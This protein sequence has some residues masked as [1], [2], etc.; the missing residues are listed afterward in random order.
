MKKIIAAALSILVAAFG[1]TIVDSTIEN[2]VA[3][4]E[5]EVIELREEIS[6]NHTT[7][8]MP[9]GYETTY[10]PTT[11]VSTTTERTDIYEGRFFDKSD[12]S[13]SKFLLRY[14]ETGRIEYI[15][16]GKYETTTT[17]VTTATEKMTTLRETTTLEP[18]I[19]VTTIDGEIITTTHFEEYDTTT[20]RKTTT[21]PTTVPSYD[22][23]FL[24]LTNSSVQITSVDI[25]EENSYW[26][27]NDYSLTSSPIDTTTMTVTATY[28]G[29]TDP[30]FAGYKVNIYNEFKSDRSNLHFYPG[31][32]FD[33]FQK[34]DNTIRS[35]GSFEYTKHIS[36]PHRTV[37]LSL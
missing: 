22:E 27:D 19:E 20:S 17:R 26:Y 29:Y 11:R 25:K 10:S 1:Y 30:I 15:S 13:K 33:E 35:D 2:R 3:S 21:L 9:T 32:R 16:P 36:F 7:A 37:I 28:K 8:Y 5:S 31:W 14:Y 4:L 23:Y 34:S 24:Y 6:K 12:S 18:T